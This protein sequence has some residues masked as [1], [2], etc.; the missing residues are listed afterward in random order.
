MWGVSP[1]YFILSSIL[2]LALWTWS[3][4]SVIYVYR[5]KGYRDDHY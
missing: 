3:I 5:Y 4:I 1:I 2:V